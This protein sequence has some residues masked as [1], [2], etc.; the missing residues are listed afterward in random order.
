MTDIE[1]VQVMGFQGKEPK[2]HYKDYPKPMFYEA[3]HFVIHKT[4]N[5]VQLLAGN[6][7]NHKIILGSTSW[8][9]RSGFREWGRQTNQLTVYTYPALVKSFFF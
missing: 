6:N 5:M 7:E 8:M 2:H 3:T 1:P 4:N 9:S